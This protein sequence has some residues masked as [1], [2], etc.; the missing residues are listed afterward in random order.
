MHETK[1]HKR[2]SFLDK[3]V[4]LSDIAFELWQWLQ[5]AQTQ[6]ELQYKVMKNIQ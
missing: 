3:L 6:D 4:V 2:N 1:D 5:H